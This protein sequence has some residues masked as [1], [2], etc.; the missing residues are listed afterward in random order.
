ML[1]QQYYLRALFCVLALLLGSNA[2]AGLQRTM[3]LFDP[4]GSSGDMYA[5]LEEFRREVKTWGVELQLRAI[6]NESVV[7]D[8]FKS[9][10]CDAIAVTGMKARQFNSFSS[11]IEAV[12]ALPEYID[13]RRL[14]EALTR[15]EAAKYLQKGDYEIAGILPI[16]SVYMFLQNRKWA[17][18]GLHKSFVGKKV[19]VFEGDE[20]SFAMI[21]NMGGLPVMANTTNF[22]GKFNNGAVDITF[23]PAVAYEPF[24]LYKGLAGGGGIVRY[25]LVQMTFQ[26]IIRSS[27]FPEGFG[28]KVRKAAYERMGY[29]LEYAYFNEKRIKPEFWVEP[30][31][32]EQA[33]LTAML[34]SARL[35]LKEANVYDHR[36]LRLMRQ[37]RCKRDPQ[38]FECINKQE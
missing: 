37:I 9:K 25:P 10:N 18:E 31:S 33:G 24:E 38:H 23:S 7:V 22:A 21:R 5:L 17:E 8:E 36:M 29:A 19:T 35:K 15:P 6:D 13:V 12:G 26:M 32:F 2:F 16:G 30:V 14:M 1:L 34:R 27:R 4:V 20:V 28:A 3:C 11:T